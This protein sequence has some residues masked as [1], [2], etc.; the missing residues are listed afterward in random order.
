MKKIS[1]FILLICL[2]LTF[3]ACKKNDGKDEQVVPTQ[4]EE[5]Q[6]PTT[7]EPVDMSDEVYDSEYYIKLSETF[8]TQMASHDFETVT[9]CFSE[10]VKSQLD[11]TMLKEVWETNVTPL[12]NFIRIHQSEFTSQDKY[13]VV[14]VLM[15]YEE[16]GVLLTF[17]YNEDNEIDGLW[18]TYKEIEDELAS[19]DKFEETSITL[20]NEPFILDG[21]LT[22]PKNVDNPPVVIL[23]Q[24]SGQS[25]MNETIGKVSNK[26]F[27]D[28]AW[29]L[30]EQGIASIR[31]NKRFYQYPELANAEMTIKDE[32]LEDAGIAIAYAKDC[33]KVD[34]TNIYVVGHSLGGMLAPKI[35]LD[36]PD[37]AGIV[38][39]AGTPR[40]LEDVIYDQNVFALASTDEYK[41]EQKEAM[42]QMVQAEIDKVKNLTE[43]DTSTILSVP[44]AY[45][46]S[47]NQI[48]TPKIL[49]Q[50]TIPMLFLQGD[51]DFQ[52]TVEKDF[53]KWKELLE[54]KDNVEFILYEGLNHLF[55][56][57][58]GAKDITDYD[59]KNNVDTKVGTDIARWIHENAKAQ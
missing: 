23:I 29:Q 59:T 43:A 34:V 54:N 32:V 4:Q 2:I 30:A 49:E 56:P 28:I 22:L 8:A 31:Y 38:S 13:I 14:C 6:E 9:Q 25:D 7:E 12:G 20:G 48:D 58:T 17:T 47:L 57:T 21:I 50:L 41:Q 11:S 55:M 46:Y 24:G 42:L 44:A 5:N 33:G 52:I 18:L 15:E 3:T 51:A 27:Q 1:I 45:W 35:A 10:N 53:A 39:L 26:P 16:N 36:N 37:V 40:K 19:N